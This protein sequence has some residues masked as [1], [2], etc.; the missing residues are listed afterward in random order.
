[1]TQRK[2][3]IERLRQ[4]RAFH[5]RIQQD[6]VVNAEGEVQPEKGCIKPTG[7]RGRIDV[8]VESDDN[9]VACAEIKNSNWDIMPEKALRRNARRQANQVWDYIESQLALGKE[10]C[11]GVIFPKRPK[12]PR[13]LR[14]I[15][16][17]FNDKGISVVWDDE[18]IDEAKA[19]ALSEKD[20]VS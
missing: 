9:L 17:L 10:V 8:F 20:N 16:Q 1:M 2:R 18:T 6:W 19:R 11:P 13:R 15:E 7:R 12:D 3:D 14:L 4:G 5:K